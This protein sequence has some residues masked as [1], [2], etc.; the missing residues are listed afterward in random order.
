MV[1]YPE[2]TMSQNVSSSCLRVRE[3]RLPVA[4]RL[5][6]IELVDHPT[7]ATLVRNVS[8]HG[9][10]LSGIGP[11]AVGEMLQVAGDGLW[12]GAR[13][14]GTVAWCDAERVG[15]RIDRFANKKSE[16]IWLGSL[17]ELYDAHLHDVLRGMENLNT[18]RD[19]FLALLEAG[20]RLREERQRRHF[21]H[22]MSLAV[23]DLANPI[24][25]AYSTIQLLT[26]GIVGVEQFMQG[27]MARV[28]ERN[29]E[30]ALGEI[31]E[32][33]SMAEATGP[34]TSLNLGDCDM[35]ALVRDVGESHLAR[36]AAKGIDLSWEAPAGLRLRADYG[37]L[38]RVLENLVNNGLKF[39][40]RG[41][42]VTV[43]A[44]ERPGAV[45]L[46]VRDTGVGMST[47]QVGKV[48]EPFNE[49]GPR[50]TDGELSHGMGLAASR[51]IILAHGGSITAASEEGR[52]S[53]F[54][55]HLP[56][57]L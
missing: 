35:E 16:R 3:A 20:E 55:V 10:C 39:T 13:A 18:E 26:S 22:T 4:P 49:D 21:A 34:L 33:L 37:K 24:S 5:A 45:I 14:A 25:S 7:S 44:E 27:G 2:A 30:R 54:T 57:L 56:N 29:C 31:E 53:V 52:G 43:S 50:P 41:G 40:K 46:R 6:R 9:L 36:A 32:L 8:R 48:F 17:I 19:E 51:G 42:A 11:I 47:E 28:I 23:H 15:L 38:H 1:G 12:D